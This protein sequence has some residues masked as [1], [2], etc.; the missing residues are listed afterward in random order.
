[1]VDFR[2]MS[3]WETGVLDQSWREGGGEKVNL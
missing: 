2:K 3:M 1:V